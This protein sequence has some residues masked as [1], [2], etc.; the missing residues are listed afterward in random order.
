LGVKMKK[1][2]IFVAEHSFWSIII[3]VCL[4]VV[5]GGILFYKYSVLPSRAEIKPT[6]QSI[7]FNQGIYQQVLD[8]W[9]ERD[10]QLQETK[11]REYFDPF[12]LNP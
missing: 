7:Q 4:E 10:R 1:V 8:K 6:E 12:E 2:P 11:T 9:S 5:A 3:V